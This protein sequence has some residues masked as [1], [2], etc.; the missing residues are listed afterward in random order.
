DTLGYMSAPAARA[1]IKTPKPDPTRGRA[2]AFLL[3]SAG[4]S[5]LDLQ[6]H[7]TQIGTLYPTYFDCDT[8]GGSLTGDDD[9][10]ITS[11][12]Q[13]RRIRVL[14]R[15]NCQEPD[16][17]HRILTDTAVR[18]STIAALIG[19]VRRNGYDGI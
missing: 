7:Y 6:R 4:E 14:P 9:P 13:L 1:S 18:N 3:A 11:W 8:T 12:A 17:V 19:L 5:F 10:A 15:F 16:A 2:H